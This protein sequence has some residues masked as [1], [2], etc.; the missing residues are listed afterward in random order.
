MAYAKPGV[1]KV[2]ISTK[3]AGVDGL[4][5]HRPGI[6]CTFQRHDNQ[7]GQYVIWVGK[8]YALI[9]AVKLHDVVRT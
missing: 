9:D 6:K 3:L 8:R 4:K 2:E 5:V 1:T 7:P